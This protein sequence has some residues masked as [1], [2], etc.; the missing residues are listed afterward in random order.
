MNCGKMTDMMPMLLNGSLGKAEEKAALEHLMECESCRRELAFWTQVADAQ[1]PF[2]K[3]FPAA[4]RERIL[5]D[6]T[7]KNPTVLGVTKQAVKV[8]FKVIEQILNV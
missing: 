8:Y 7:R 1:A 2:E 5:D 3:E 4:D 6:L